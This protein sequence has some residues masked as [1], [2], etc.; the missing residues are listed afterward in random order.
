MPKAPEFV[1]CDDE[2]IVDYF[3]STRGSLV[4]SNKTIWLST[5]IKREFKRGDTPSDTTWFACCFV[6]CLRFVLL[7]YVSQ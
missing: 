7:S 2:R 6:S 5:E 3:L 1:C 4:V